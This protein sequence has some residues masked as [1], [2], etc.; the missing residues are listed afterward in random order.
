[1]GAV[2]MFSDAVE[3]GRGDKN[4]NDMEGPKKWR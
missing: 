3:A 2:E 4:E 1:M